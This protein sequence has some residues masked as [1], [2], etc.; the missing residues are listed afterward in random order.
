MAVHLL[1]CIAERR[2]RDRVSSRQIRYRCDILAL[3]W[4][5][6]ISAAELTALCAL[7]AAA[8]TG[9]ADDPMSTQDTDGET[10]GRSLTRSWLR[11]SCAC[12]RLSVRVCVCALVCA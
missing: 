8:R 2:L 1:R 11:S 6:I 3:D 7:A 12:V 5:H 4:R 10:D 9:I